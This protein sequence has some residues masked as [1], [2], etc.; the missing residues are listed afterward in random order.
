MKTGRGAKTAPAV[1][2]GRPARTPSRRP[3]VL[4]FPAKLE[5]MVAK[6]TQDTA[7]AWLTNEKARNRRLGKKLK[8]IKPL[9]EVM[10][11]SKHHHT[12]RT[13]A[14]VSQRTRL[15]H[16]TPHTMVELPEEVYEGDFTSNVIHEQKDFKM[17]I[18]L[19][20]R[21]TTGK[22]S[23]VMESAKRMYPSQNW[24]FLNS[25]LINQSTAVTRNVWTEP[26][27]R[28]LDKVLY[29]NCGFNR[30]GVFRPW[31]QMEKLFNISG[32]SQR[33][34][35]RASDNWGVACGPAF[36]DFIHMLNGG[37]NQ[38]LEPLLIPGGDQDL[39]LPIREF[40]KRYEIQN[41]N[42]QLPMYASI[43]I[44]APTRDQRHQNNPFDDWWDPFYSQKS[45]SATSTDI[46][47]MRMDWNFSYKPQ[48]DQAASPPS[49]SNT[50]YNCCN[51]TE[52]CPDATPYLSR[53]FTERWKVLEVSKVRLLPQQTCYLDLEQIL[54]SPTSLKR[55]LP[56][57]WADAQ[58]GASYPYKQ[59]DV[60]FEGMSL[61]PMIKFWGENVT[62]LDKGDTVVQE[63]P[64][65]MMRGREG[66]GPCTM[67]VN[68]VKDEVRYYAASTRLRETS[69]DWV[70][71]I[72]NYLDQPGFIAKSRGISSA[73][74]LVN[75]VWAFI[76][77]NGSLQNRPAQWN[78]DTN[79]WE[80]LP[81]SKF[82]NVSIETVS[83]TTT[84]K[85]EPV[86]GSED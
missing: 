34:D 7:G 25:G 82:E 57:D 62:A 8:Q 86:A 73:D 44:C 45:V 64:S 49:P 79:A 42:T 38:G 12:L 76:N 6:V 23:K 52:V 31:H 20:F 32:V 83:T 48:M 24:N 29:A 77:N 26:I 37:V 47:T 10:D 75:F 22:R 14:G 72:R 51:A 19:K 54:N 61:V 68:I 74:S 53:K 70:S 21:R 40:R 35:L 63:L 78:P 59:H 55:V 43:Y 36:Y 41:T 1:T 33:D 17:P 30:S 15:K 56:Q 71:P 39:L 50:E 60:F 4:S 11:E 27:H 13:S 5:K 9:G 58:D 66:S 3:A 67:R 80:S 46:D 18:E 65:V 16:M 81:A 84:Q 28:L 85:L 69:P 2:R